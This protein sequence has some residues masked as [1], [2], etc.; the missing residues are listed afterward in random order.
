MI[1]ELECSEAFLPEIK[2][3]AD[4]EV[5]GEARP[6]DFDAAGQVVPLRH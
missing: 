6:L 1:G 4:L 2:K 3:R 5:V